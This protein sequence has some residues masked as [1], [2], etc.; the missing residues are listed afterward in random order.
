[1]WIQL[2]CRPSDIALRLALPQHL[3]SWRGL[4]LSP[5]CSSPRSR[6]DGS[7]F[8]FW[9][10]GL[11][12]R[13]GSRIVL[14]SLALLLG[15]VVIAMSRVQGAAML[16]VLITLTRGL[17]QSALSV[18]SLATPGKW[19]RRRLTWAMGVYAVVMSIGFMMAFPSVGALVLARGWRVAWAVVGA[20]QCGR[21]RRPSKSTSSTP[22]GTTAA[23][24]FS[25]DRFSDFACRLPQT[26]RILMSQG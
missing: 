20:V 19:F 14:T 2:V 18:V 22:I 4:H 16:L 17:W 23:A 6:I 24:T 8:C 25:K 7:V 12:D 1:V 21:S 15:G 26:A 13:H 9:I 5:S 3:E 11:V 10:G